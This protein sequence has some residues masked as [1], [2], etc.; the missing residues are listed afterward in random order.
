VKTNPKMEALLAEIHDD[1][2]DDPQALPQKLLALLN[3]GFVEEQE[4]VFFSRLKKESQ[5]QKLDFPDRTAYECFVNHV[6]VEDYLENGGLPPLELLGRGMAFAH[7]LA[8]RLR[9]LHGTKH[10][11]VIV[12]SDGGV[13]CTVRFHTLRH[14]EEW[15]GKN[16]DGFKEQ[17]IA[18]LETQEFLP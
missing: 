16:S 9:L 12:A 15:V 11:R 2:L 10:F 7:E 6:H 3:E 18:I 8:D 4:C 1:N 5:V 13:S 17:A 14:E